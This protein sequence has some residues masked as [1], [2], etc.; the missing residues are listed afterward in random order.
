MNARKL[1]EFEE[2]YDQFYV[3]TSVIRV[4]GRDLVRDLFLSITATEVE[5]GLNTAGRFSFTIAGAFDWKERE[6]LGKAAL[7]R[8]D[9]LDLFAFGAQVEVSIGY[10]KA[11][12]LRPMLKAIVTEIGTG[13]AESG[14]PSLTVSGF[15]A[16]Y[17]L[18]I[19]KNSCQW[20]DKT[21]SEAVRDVAGRNSLPVS[22]TAQ[23]T[24]LPRIDQTKES[25]RDFIDRMAKLAKSV[26]YIRDGT[27]CFGPRR[28][29]SGAVAELAWGEGLS[30]FSPTAN[31]AKQISE[32]EVHGWSATE[33]KHVVGRAKA[34]DEKKGDG[35]ETGSRRIGKAL[36]NSPVLSISA[37]V[38]SQQDADE[39]AKAILEERAQDLVTGDGECVG[40]PD[41]VPD[42]RVAIAGVGRAF[43]KNYYVTDTTHSLDGKGYRTRLKVEE[44]SI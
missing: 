7:E 23:D 11:A 18:G 26:F 44:R 2:G 5:L 24:A 19:G 43:S 38:H 27:L 34:G 25:D 12:R 35:G 28:L 20:E 42:T 10:G 16:L 1:Y 15:D 39:R 4:G 29:D 30:S 33:G 40:L 41:L 36:S 13:F 3:P 17:P 31:I 6:F 21:P 14:T 8:V 22:I 32:V 9:L 37:A